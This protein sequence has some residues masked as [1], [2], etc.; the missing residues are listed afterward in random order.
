MYAALQSASRLTLPF[1]DKPKCNM[2]IVIIADGIRCKG[3]LFFC[4]GRLHKSNDRGGGN[5]K[6]HFKAKYSIQNV[7]N[8]TVRGAG[9][10][11]VGSYNSGIYNSG[12]GGT[13]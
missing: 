11:K 6:S 5:T 10:D 7:G 2:Q 8:Q 3:P 4:H 9:E 12:N 1:T 13:I